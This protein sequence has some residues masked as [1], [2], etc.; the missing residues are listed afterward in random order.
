[1][2]LDIKNEIAYSIYL[3]KGKSEGRMDLLLLKKDNSLYV[4]IQNF[5]SFMHNKKSY[6]NIFV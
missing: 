5:N 4:Y 1:M 3:I 6:E 2:Y